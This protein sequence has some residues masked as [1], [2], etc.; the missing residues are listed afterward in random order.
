MV[1][2]KKTKKQLTRDKSDS[3]NIIC[4]KFKQEENL[5]SADQQNHCSQKF[6]K[7]QQCIF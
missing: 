1:M 6:L 2:S 4:Q 5:R 7:K 3:W